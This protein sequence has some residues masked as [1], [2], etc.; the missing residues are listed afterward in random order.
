MEKKKKAS[1][2]VELIL[3]VQ[4]DTMLSPLHHLKQCETKARWPWISA[5]PCDDLA[6]VIFNSVQSSFDSVRHDENLNNCT[7]NACVFKNCL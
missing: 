4:L 5:V 6:L 7:A 3:K 1:S 2:D